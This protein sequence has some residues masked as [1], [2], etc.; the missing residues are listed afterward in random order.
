MRGIEGSNIRVV[1]EVVYCWPNAPSYRTVEEHGHVMLLNY[2]F[3]INNGHEFEPDSGLLM[4]HLCKR[5]ISKLLRDV[6]FVEPDSQKLVC[7]R[8]FR[9]ND[10]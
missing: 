1:D 3:S 5:Y 9:W 6:Q 10:H 8:N 4:M 2:A 7:V